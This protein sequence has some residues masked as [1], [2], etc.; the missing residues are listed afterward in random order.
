MRAGLQKSCEYVQG[1]LQWEIEVVKADIV[2]L[3][4]AE[5]GLWD[6]LSHRF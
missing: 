2:L 3:W 4:G 6:I 1:I 5:P